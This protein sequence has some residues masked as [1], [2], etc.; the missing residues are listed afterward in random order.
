MWELLLCH[1]SSLWLGFEVCDDAGCCFTMFLD[2]DLSQCC[3]SGD[4]GTAASNCLIMFLIGKHVLI[5]L[6]GV[7][8]SNSI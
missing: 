1:S 5:L 4:A 6:P 8:L 7:R 3:I 2:L